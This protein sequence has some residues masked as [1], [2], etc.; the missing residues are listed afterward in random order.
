[1]PVKSSRPDV[2]PVAGGGTPSQGLWDAGTQGQR[3][4]SDVPF[5]AA[6]ASLQCEGDV[7]STPDSHTEKCR[8]DHAAYQALAPADHQMVSEPVAK[9]KP[10]IRI[11]EEALRD[12]GLTRSEAKRVLA[13]GY[14]ALGQRDVGSD[15]DDVAALRRILQSIKGTNR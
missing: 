10:Q 1:M 12:A 3:K 14:R 11:L 8:V 9:A 13:S 6:D 5:V 7:T 4:S 2:T 15:A